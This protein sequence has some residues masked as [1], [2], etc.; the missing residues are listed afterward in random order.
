MSYLSKIKDRYHTV[1]AETIRTL[2]VPAGLVAIGLL[3]RPFLGLT[4][5]SEQIAT[6]ILIW[7]LFAASFNLLFGYVGLL[8]FGHA[9]F[10]GTGVYV[11][12]IGISVFGLPFSLL[13]LLGIVIASALA[14]AI[15]RIT[16]RYGEIYF[17]MLTLAFAMG[18]HFIVNSNPYGLTGGSDGL[19][20]GTTPEWI[21]SFRGQRAIDV[22]W[23]VDLL[24]LLGLEPSYYWFVA[25]VFVA[26]MLLLWQVVRSPFGR[27]LVAIRDN[28]DL[29]RAMGISTNRYKVWAFTLSGGFSAIAGALLMISNYGAAVANFGPETSANVL[30]MTIFGGA[31]LFFGPLVGALSWFGVRELLQSIEVLQLPILGAIEIGAVVSY[32]QFFFGLAF[33]LVILVSPRDGLWGYIR[34]YAVKTFSATKR[35]LE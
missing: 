29:A 26:T 15:G 33:V 28:E 23:Y 1:D 9:M 31:N 20:S 18:I 27:T 17:A 10:L 19:R 3:I 11:T 32:W 16:V 8:S 34:G 4:I 30:L 35:W 22:D 7:M 6:T 24:S 21:T 25:A 2:R 5:G 13:T 12:A 14:Y